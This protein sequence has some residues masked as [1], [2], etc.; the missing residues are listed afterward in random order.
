MEQTELIIAALGLAWASGLNLYAGL[1]TLGILGATGQF[2]LPPDLEVLG[3]P[4]VIAAAVFMYCV[5]FVADK[6]PGVDTTWD[7]LHTF[8][9]IPAGA[10]LAL[11][12][13]GELDPAIQVAALIVGGSVAASSHAFKAGSR[14]LINTSPE[15]FSNWGAS[16]VE[17]GLVIGGVTLAVL[18]PMAFSVLIILFFALAIWLMPKIWRGIKT[19][20]SRLRQI[21]GGEKNDDLVND[22][23][24]TVSLKSTQRP[25]EPH[26]LS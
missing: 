24:I 26:S 16:L 5:E 13:V 19:L 7:T 22:G 2:D 18:Q 9:R 8:I 23:R 25:N 1:A 14:V 21:F 17:D 4:V 11:G 15:P 6:I 3:N 20:W 12:A 10:V